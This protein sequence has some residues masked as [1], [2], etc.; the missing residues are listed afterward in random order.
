MVATNQETTA[1]AKS[2]ASAGAPNAAAAMFDHGMFSQMQRIA[3]AMGRSSL[4]P[5][6]LKGKTAEETIGNCLRVVNQALRWEF[7]PFAVAD[8]SYVVRGK[9]GYQGKLVA[10]VVNARAKLKSKLQPLYNEES[11]DKFAV[12]IYGSD[13]DVPRDAFPLLRAYAKSEDRKALA[14]LTEMGV[15]CVRLSVAQGKTDNQMWKSDPEQKLFYSGVTKWARRHS[16]EVIMGVLTDSDL[17]T[18]VLDAQAMAPAPTSSMEALTQRLE[19]Q[20][21]GEEESAEPE[22]AAD[23][24]HAVSDLEEIRQEI[25]EADAEKVSKLYDFYVGP[26][27]PLGPADTS[28]V[29]AW[30]KSRSAE[31]AKAGKSSGVLF[32]DGMS[33]TEAGM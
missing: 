15:K 31:L 33:A 21:E 3:T 10:A 4:V 29:S 28:Q 16:P 18:I 19:Q 12:V 5:A 26:N 27:G 6:H 24:P 17:E 11:G 25:L 14:D 9:L 30:C 7:D 2:T 23:E 32:D 22:A 13:G 8:E 20:T 1:I